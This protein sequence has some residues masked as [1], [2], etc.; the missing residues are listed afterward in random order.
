MTAA[1][2][3][4]EAIMDKPI[5][6]TTASDL[7][8]LT[9]LWEA[10]FHDDKSFIDPF[11]Q[12]FF[13][14]RSTLVW[15]EA[16]EILAMLYYLPGFTLAGPELPCAMLYAF[17]T[18]PEHQGRGL[19]TAL[20]QYGVGYAWRTFGAYTV[21]HPANPGLFSFYRAAIGS[22]P[23]FRA[24]EAQFA[25]A[26]GRGGDRLVLEQVDAEA[27]GPLRERF[28]KPIS[29]LRLPPGLLPFQESLCGN[30]GGFFS[31]E[32]RGQPLAAMVEKEGDTLFFKELLGVQAADLSA[33]GADLAA[34]LGA[35]VAV[36]V[37]GGPGDTPFAVL[38]GPETTP[39]PPLPSA[40]WYGPALD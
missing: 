4:W 28:L 23:L 24:R 18:R 31:G 11:H 6:T 7:P 29:H 14:P 38:A 37:P 30:G 36:R 21:L 2:L 32:W 10:V 17:C 35:P 19:G 22:I 3:F 8:A 33:L 25:P 9:A 34:A 16:G 12:A 40:A 27:Y 5:Q 20:A 1:L 15:R 39:L 26:P 13:T